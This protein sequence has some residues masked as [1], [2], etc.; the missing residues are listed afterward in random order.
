MKLE[1]SLESCSERQASKY[2]VDFGDLYG[3]GAQYIK[4]E[5]AR[6]Q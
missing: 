6:L 3:E 5:Q 4:I 2:G 1:T